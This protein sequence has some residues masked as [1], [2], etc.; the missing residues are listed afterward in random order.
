MVKGVFVSIKE[1]IENTFLQTRHRERNFK[2]IRK[3]LLK[4]LEK[5]L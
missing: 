1:K 5:N 3:S 2:S 4:G